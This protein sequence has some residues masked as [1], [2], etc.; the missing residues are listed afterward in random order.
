MPGGCDPGMA[1]HSNDPMSSYRAIPF[2][3]RHP[4]WFGI[5]PALCS[6]STLCRCVRSACIAPKAI[7]IG[8][9]VERYYRVRELVFRVVPTVGMRGASRPLASFKML[10]LRH[11]TAT[12]IRKF[13]DSGCGRASGE[14]LPQTT[15]GPPRYSKTGGEVEPACG[16]KS[17]SGL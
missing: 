7:L 13:R 11:A 1:R 8:G 9:V 3:S 10:W 17:F 14:F 5:F 6:L 2:R 16:F 15:V 4:T 12:I